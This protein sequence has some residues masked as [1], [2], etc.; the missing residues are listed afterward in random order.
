MTEILAHVYSSEST[1]QELTNEY[2]WFSKNVASFFFVA[3]AWDGLN[4]LLKVNPFLDGVH[5]KS[6]TYG[7]FETDF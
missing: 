2:R 4:C 7:H 1:Q 5:I 6:N 3:L